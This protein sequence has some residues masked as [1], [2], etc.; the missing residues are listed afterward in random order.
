MFCFNCSE[1][2]KS[3]NRFLKAQNNDYETA[4]EEIK[5][6]KKESH[7]IWYIFPQIKGL[8][9]SYMDKEYSI[10][11]IQ[12]TLEYINNKTLWKRL[13]EITKLL[14]KIPHNDIREVMWYPDDLK[15]RSCMTLFSIVSDDNEVFNK[16]IDKFYNGEKDLKTVNILK[17]MLNK[18]KKDLDEKIYNKIKEKCIT[19][20]KEEN[21]K[22]EKRRLRELKEKEEREKKLKEKMKE[23]EKEKLKEIMEKQKEK[24]IEENEKNNEKVEEKKYE[25]EKEEKDKKLNDQK[26]KEKTEK[27]E[28]IKGDKNEEKENKEKDKYKEQIE[29]QKTKEE[30]EKIEKEKKEKEKKEKIEKEK[31]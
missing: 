25:K 28:K 13:V 11:S 23:R 21:E 10:K 22:I 18:E 16:V 27:D 2:T 1:E 26:L 29:K 15:L 7:W 14:L 12:E 19:I 5:N 8:G 3:I 4:Y 17:S 24:I 20:E 31:I 9:M 6:G 30:K